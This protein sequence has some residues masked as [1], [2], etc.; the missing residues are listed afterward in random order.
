MT[1]HPDIS[2]V[3]TVRLHGWLGALR[4]LKIDRL[5]MFAGVPHY[6]RVHPLQTLIS[7]FLVTHGW[8]WRNNSRLKAVI[9]EFHYREVCIWLIAHRSWFW[10]CQR[11]FGNC[12][13]GRTLELVL[14]WVRHLVINQQLLLRLLSCLG[15]DI[16]WEDMFCR[17]LFQM[18]GWIQS[19]LHV[20]LHR[21][22]CQN[23]VVK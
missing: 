1:A 3:D 9:M 22:L 7:S 6:V 4:K 8:F 19:V 23:F 13:V 20:L 14:L 17:S 18:M 11:S 15:E 5:G 21:A 10:W 12:E 16:S 2:P